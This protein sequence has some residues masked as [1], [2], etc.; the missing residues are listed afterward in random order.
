MIEEL[1]KFELKKVSL[2]YKNDI[3]LNENR[4]K[5]IIELIKRNKLEEKKELRPLAWKL[6]LNFLNAD[7][8][9]EK[10]IEDIDSKRSEYKNKIKKYFKVDKDPLINEEEDKRNISNDLSTYINLINLDLSRTHQDIDLFHSQKTKTILSNVLNIYARECNDVPYGQGMN[11]LISM[12]YIV[13]YPYYFPNSNKNNR[14]EIKEYL[15]DIESHYEDIYLFFH[16][17]KEIE[18][19][20]FFLFES[21]MSKGIQN[22]YSKDLA[23]DLNLYQLFPGDYKDILNE[24]KPTH[25]NIRASMIIHDKLKVIDKRLYNHFNNIKINCN[26]FLHR[27]L[28]CIFTREF[29]KEDSMILW[30]RIFLY[31][32][33]KGNKFK[34]KLIYIDFI[35]VSMILRIRNKLIKKEEGDCFTILF[36][37][38]SGDNISELITL[39]EKVSELFEKKINNEEYFIDEIFNLIKINSNSREEDNDGSGDGSDELIISP[40]TYNQSKNNSFIDCDRK[41]ENIILFNRC[42]IKIKYFIIAILC[43]IISILLLFYFNKIK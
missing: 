25:L 12:L 35:C 5:T 15:N 32:Y 4:E 10:W 7:D 2:T 18:C 42:R 38:P 1:K 22:I 16:D 30:D 13:F 14:E 36:H 37:Y 27:W 39:T 19:D 33:L 34:Y 20:L 23:E 40:H 24:D 17:E 28:K 41:R 31:E 9:L 6:F 3:L 43:V 21:L 11:E 29:N 26:Y 8:T